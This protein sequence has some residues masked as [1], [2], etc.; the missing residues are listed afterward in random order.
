MKLLLSYSQV[1][2]ELTACGLRY[3]EAESVL[4]RRDLLPPHPHGLHSHRRWLRQT[5]IDFCAEVQKG[6][7]ALGEGCVRGGSQSTVNFRP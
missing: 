2:E 3:R 1:F 4:A 7:I 6:G 5:V